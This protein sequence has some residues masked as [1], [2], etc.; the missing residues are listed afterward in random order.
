[1]QA[2]TPRA[3]AVLLLGSVGRRS[4][5]RGMHGCSRTHGPVTTTG[6]GESACAALFLHFPGAGGTAL[7]ARLVAAGRGMSHPKHP[8]G[9]G[10]CLASQ[11]EWTHAMT[12]TGRRCD[13]AHLHA[14]M[15]ETGTQLWATENVVATPLGCARVSYWI[16]LRSPVSRILS[17][18]YKRTL[19]GMFARP[20][21]VLEA[22]NRTMLLNSSR[23]VPGMPEF[24]G[25]PAVDNNYVRSLGGPSV[26]RLGLGEITEGHLAMAAERLATMNVVPMLN[27]SSPAT[28]RW[29]G[30]TPHVAGRGIKVSGSH[31]RVPREVEQDLAFV[32]ALRRHNEL[33]SRLYLFAVELYE[34]RVASHEKILH[35]S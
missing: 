7:W 8:T 18:M 9:N 26:Y 25:T 27:I 31:A 1:M 30:L 11:W 28:A 16:A 5:V 3:G 12:T 32:A 6:A 33:D 34:R 22:L 2:I 15:R 19:F 17:R 24:S 20:G 23:S 4:G 13:C 10:G 29:M 35:F 21:M 14:F